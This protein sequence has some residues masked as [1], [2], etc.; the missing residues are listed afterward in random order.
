MQ[1]NDPTTSSEREGRA[2]WNGMPWGVRVACRR[3]CRPTNRLPWRAAMSVSEHLAAK[4][5]QWLAEFMASTEPRQAD[6]RS[7]GPLL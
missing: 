1:G 6:H 5:K 4:I 2:G 3:R 7:R